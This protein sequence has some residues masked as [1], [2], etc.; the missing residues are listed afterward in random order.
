MA[1][2]G[3]GWVQIEPLSV[4]EDHRPEVLGLAETGGQALDLLNLAV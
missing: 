4:E 1:L 3:S 2:P